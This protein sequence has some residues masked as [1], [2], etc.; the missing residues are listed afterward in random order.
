LY[1][2]QKKYTMFGLFNTKTK[3]YQ[4]INAAG[5]QQ[6]MQETKDAQI[7]DVRSE[8]E[9]RQGHIPGAKLINLMSG[10]AQEQLMKLP[11]D[12]TI[13]LYCRSGNRSGMAAQ[14]LGDAGFK[15]VYNLQG[16][17]NYWNGPVER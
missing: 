6:H 3:T 10:K 5:F 8:M 9:Y 14:Q 13:L 11:R 12:K 16:G 15:K 7:I 17:L 2:N 1:H 4:D